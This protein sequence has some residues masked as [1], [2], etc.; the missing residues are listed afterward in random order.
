M[1][2]QELAQFCREQ[3]GLEAERSG[4]IFYSKPELLKRGD[5]YLMGYNPG[6]DGGLPLAKN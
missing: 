4:G 2:P 3:L 6:G 1:T 5:V